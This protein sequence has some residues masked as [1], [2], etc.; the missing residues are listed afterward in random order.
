MNSTQGLADGVF[1]GRFA[2]KKTETTVNA[3][4]GAFPMTL[5]QLI[6]SPS[7]EASRGGPKE[8]KAQ[9]PKVSTEEEKLQKALLLVEQL[10]GCGFRS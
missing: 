5:A 10:R 6:N 1:P 7:V 8:L 2:Q 4:R 9:A 3:K